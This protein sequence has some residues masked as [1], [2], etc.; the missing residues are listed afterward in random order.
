M[1][2]LE[3][4]L[5][6]AKDLIDYCK[7]Y[8]DLYRGA[9]TDKA[10]RDELYSVIGEIVNMPSVQPDNRIA[11]IADLVE[12]T[13]DHFELDDAMDL[14]YQIKEILGEETSNVRALPSVQPERWDTC[15]SCP[16]SHGCPVIKG[17]TNDQ[18]EQYAGEIPADCPLDKESAQP[19]H[20]ELDFVQ[21]HKKIG[22]KLKVGQPER[23][24]TK[25]EESIHSMFDH[26][27]DCE[28]DHP[29]F[30]DT[31]GDLMTAVIQ[32]FNNSAQPLRKKGK[33]ISD[34][35]IPTKC[36]FCGEHWNKYIFGD[37]VWYTGEVPKFCPECG[38]DMRGE[39]DGT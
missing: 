16:L 11:K 6:S 3:I 20:E 37:E 7:S 22:V 39:Q 4:K 17:C 23:K 2:S 21:P 26:I 30:Q 28:I 8:I 29:A 36:P 24:N 25:F 32:A 12:G 9:Q 13:I 14:L 38:C 5:I 35:D 33:W 15:F 34:G 31:V 10:R 1:D 27:W 19:E 18:A